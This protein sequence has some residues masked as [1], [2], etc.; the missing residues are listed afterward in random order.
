MRR[1]FLAIC[2]ATIAFSLWGYFWYA[3][4]LDDVWQDL[5]NTSE[6]DLIAMANRRGSIQH[7]LTILILSL[8]HI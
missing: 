5:I 1:E 3:T 4:L 8:I 6:A 2:L 7:V